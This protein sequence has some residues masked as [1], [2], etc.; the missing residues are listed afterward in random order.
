MPTS[1][2]A[3]CA[4]CTAQ[5]ACVRCCGGRGGF[6]A[7]SLACLS[8]AHDCSHRYPVYV[9]DID[10]RQGA[11]LDLLDSILIFML[12]LRFVANACVT[13]PPDGHGAAMGPR[14]SSDR[15]AC[16]EPPSTLLG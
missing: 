11:N 5:G 7:L 13:S 10:I 12:I 1:G 16:G 14:N 15:M 8:R 3:S 9:P 6:L 4:G 2:N